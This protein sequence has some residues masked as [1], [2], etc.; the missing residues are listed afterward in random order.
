MG[1]KD[2]SAS[3]N[4]LIFSLC[5]H[6]GAQLQLNKSPKSLKLI[7]AIFDPGIYQKKSSKKSKHQ[8]VGP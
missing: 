8:Y 7:L 1:T 5:A 6:F 3:K 2:A 4:G